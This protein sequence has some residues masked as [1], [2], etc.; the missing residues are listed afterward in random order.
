[1][2]ELNSIDIVRNIRKVDNNIYN[3]FNKLCIGE[4]WSKRL[5]I[6]IKVNK[7]LRIRKIYINIY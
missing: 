1:M 7:F 2:L 4:I 6:F 5:L 3:I